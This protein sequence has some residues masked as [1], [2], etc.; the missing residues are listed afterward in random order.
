MYT[1]KFYYD[2]NIEIGIDRYLR[3]YV[4]FFTLE[5]DQ[6]KEKQEMEDRQSK[7]REAEKDRLEKEAEDAHIEKEDAAKREKDASDE[8]ENL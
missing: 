1:M 3:R 5:D 4:D 6:A 8:A 2:S 7:E